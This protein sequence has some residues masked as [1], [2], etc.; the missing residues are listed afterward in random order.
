[1]KSERRRV[2]RPSKYG[3][4][5]LPRKP[6]L[7]E[8]RRVGRPSK[9][10]PDKLSLG[11]T[12]KDAP[13]K[14]FR[15]LIKR[16]AIILPGAYD[17]LSALLIERAG[18]E[19][20]YLSGAGLANAAGLPDIGLLTLTEVVA[21]VGYITRA[22]RI[23]AI[24]DADTGFGEGLHLA[25]TVAL[26]ESAGTAGI[27]IEDQEFP[28]RCGHLPGKSLIPAK[29]MAGKI[30]AAAGAREDPDFVIIARTDARG[31]TGF[32]DAVDRAKRYLDAGADLIF[33]EALQ[34]EEEF[35]KFAKEVPAPLLANMTE[36][37]VS[38]ALSAGALSK[39]GYRV[40]LFPM[41][42]LRIAAKAMEE[43]LARLKEE[44]T[45]KGMLGAMQP[46]GDL[47]RLVRYAEFE[48]LDLALAS[49]SK[50]RRR[51]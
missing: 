4:D 23:P 25:R 29:E 37:G 43:G 36:F 20:V 30:K 48:D 39:M 26:F 28:K 11:P 50:K 19:A 16:N 27:Q 12:L 17:A 51:R 3:P 10:G 42:L 49:E 32:R 22:V 45:S 41:S 31:V 40:I 7:S 44:G 33:P 21:Q 9:Y 1:M 14:R 18:F 8:R 6:I 38:P 35:S 46:R 24:A 15:R 5:N 34:S 2:G 47:Y 13:G